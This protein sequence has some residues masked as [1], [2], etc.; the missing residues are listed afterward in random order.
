MLSGDQGTCGWYVHSLAHDTVFD[1]GRDRFLL[2]VVTHLPK[3]LS[4]SRGDVVRVDGRDV[5]C[6]VIVSVGGDLMECCGSVVG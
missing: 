4:S 5:T 1:G 3:I 6:E 2:G